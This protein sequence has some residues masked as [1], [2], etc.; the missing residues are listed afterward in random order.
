MITS[1]RASHGDIGPHQNASGS[2]RV[3][4]SSTKQRTRPKFDGL[5]KWLPAPLDHVL[6]EDRHR[7]RA[8]ED[9]PALHAPPVAVLGAGNAQDE[10]D[11][12]A[13][14][15]RARRPH[16]HA[17]AAERDREL[18]HRAGEE[19][20]EDLG[21]RE[22]E[23]ERRLAQDLQRDDD[24]REVQARV[25]NRRQQ[26]RVRRP[27][28]PERRPRRLGQGGRVHGVPWYWR[29]AAGLCGNLGCPGAFGGRLRRSPPRS[30][31]L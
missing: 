31:S 28:D 15:E 13:R 29:R 24:G 27:A 22:L 14:Q 2:A 19:R 26:D 4:P 10:G 18:D 16:D 23:V 5:K 3:A 12:V 25:A 17:L 30:F 9:P 20:D 21:D 7:G 8:G 6:R 1:A 11:A